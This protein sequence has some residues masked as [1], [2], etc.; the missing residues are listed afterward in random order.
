VRLVE[1]ASG[2]AFVTRLTRRVGVVL[3]H[4]AERGV[5]VRWDDEAPDKYVHGELAVDPHAPETGE[6]E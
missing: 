3:A 4:T 2:D 5:L 1:A 6:G